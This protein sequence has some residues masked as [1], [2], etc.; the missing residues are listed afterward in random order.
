MIDNWLGRR[1]PMLA[2]AR[3]NLSRARARTALA[4]AGITIG[5][6]AIASLGM[7]GVAFQQ[8]ILQ[9][10][11]TVTQS[12]WLT[13][14]EDADFAAFEERHL[15]EVRQYVDHPVYTMQQES[16]GVEAKKASTGATIYGFSHPGEFATADT[17]QIPD[18]WRSGALVGPDLADS[19]DVQTG[20]SVVVD[21]E[22][23]RILAVL[24]PTPQS[25]FVRTDNA[26][27]LPPSQF[28]R[29]T[30]DLLMVRTDSP[31]EA[32]ETS[33]DLD[34]SLN[35]G[36]DERYEVNDAEQLIDQFN[37]QMA[38]INTFL[39]AIGGI[40]LVVASVSIFNVMLMSAIERK[41]EIGVLRAV[42]YHRLDVLRLM[43]AEAILL[44]LGGAFVGVVLSVLLGMAINA[45]LLS[46]PLAFTTEAL[47]Y[48]VMGF[49][50]GTL[51]SF[52]S[53]LYPAWKAANARPVEAL[54]D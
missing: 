41:E 17:G 22:R 3:N 12:V 26:V 31:N 5:V 6:L 34:G 23:H 18:N 8:S 39:L 16:A 27:L 14:G 33:E 13:P 42:G 28:D 9:G 7:G 40:S 30:Y 10:A 46:D 20:D 2:F 29:S 49:V 4:M 53:G 44:G 25:S 38:T 50:F 48:A 37:Q 47:Q 11:D 1:F 32:F 51:A 43:L 36:R 45:E 15:E 24:E 52:L 35:P 54:R 21:G 19:L